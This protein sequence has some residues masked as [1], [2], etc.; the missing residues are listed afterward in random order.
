MRNPRPSLAEAPNVDV[1]AK[2]ILETTKA[3]SK[4]R[5]IVID[6]GKDAI[7]FSQTLAIER[8][9]RTDLPESLPEA[10]RILCDERLVELRKAASA[11]LEPWRQTYQE[12]R[13]FIAQAEYD[14]GQV[15][16]MLERERANGIQTG[17]WNMLVESLFPPA[18]PRRALA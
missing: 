16:E 14:G 5:D 15:F 3:A 10:I 1:K 4:Y 17:R 8:N 9:R 11:I 7:A 13:E 2:K 6:T 18:E 12:G